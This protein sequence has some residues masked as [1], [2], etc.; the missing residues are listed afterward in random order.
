MKYQN[1]YSILILGNIILFA[2]NIFLLYNYIHYYN[3]QSY[4]NKNY[5]YTSKCQFNSTN[6]NMSYNRLMIK[7]NVINSDISFV[8]LYYPLIFI[9]NTKNS[10]FNE[11][12]NGDFNNF[13]NILLNKTFTCVFN[14]K[15]NSAYFNDYNNYPQINNIEN[16]SSII[17]YL[18]ISLSIFI[19]IQLV[20]NSI[21]CI[22]KYK[23]YLLNRNSYIQL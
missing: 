1:K 12:S 10:Y 22:T 23:Q 11:N 9:G 2:I 5:T 15:T 7:A 17:L 20:F 4:I 8:H 19:I 14:T 18:L 6:Y 16:L 13:I 3:I 21:I